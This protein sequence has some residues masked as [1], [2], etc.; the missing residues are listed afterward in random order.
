ME[1]TDWTN[2]NSLAAHA[3][4]TKYIL[5]ASKWQYGFHQLKDQEIKITLGLMKLKLDK[6]PHYLEMYLDPHLTWENHLKHIL[7]SC[8]TTLSVLQKMKN[9]T[10]FRS[11]KTLTESLILSKFDSNDNVILL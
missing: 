10:P 5:G 7:S 4:K 2:N 8:Y 6:E 11:C 9:F 1:V 3:V